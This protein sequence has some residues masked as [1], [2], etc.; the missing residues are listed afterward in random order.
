LL[1]KPQTDDPDFSVSV[2]LRFVLG[3]VIH[4]LSNSISG[5]SSLS[6]FHLRGVVADPELRESLE[7]IQQSADSSRNLIVAVASFLNPMRSSEEILKAS[8][9]VRETGQLISLLIPKSLQFETRIES[10][11]SDLIYV[12][13][14]LFFSQVVTAA[15]LQFQETRAPVGKVSLE[16]DTKGE[17][18]EVGY[19]SSV[20]PP[21]TFDAAL[22][23]RFG[24]VGPDV[25]TR[26]ETTDQYSKVIVTFPRANLPPSP[27]IQAFS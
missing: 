13:R 15:A 6:R 4:D 23:D 24:N 25:T 14:D 1:E 10:G 19:R 17:W 3:R 18:I 11:E 21:Y 16:C 5:I 9:L 22:I 26:V 20:E 27:N 7:L 12:F 2:C 8:D